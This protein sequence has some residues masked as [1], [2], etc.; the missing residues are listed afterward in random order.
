MVGYFMMI[1][2]NSSLYL[3]HVYWGESFAIAPSHENLELL[4]LFIWIEKAHGK[5]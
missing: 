4:L 5:T 3:N 2:A 1:V